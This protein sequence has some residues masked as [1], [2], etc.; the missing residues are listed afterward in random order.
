MGLELNFEGQE[1]LEKPA[2]GEAFQVEGTNRVSKH[3]DFS[4]PEGGLGRQLE[5]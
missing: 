4:K 5:G 1:E 3:R 2:K